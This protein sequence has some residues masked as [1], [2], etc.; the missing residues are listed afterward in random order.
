MFGP[1]VACAAR[2]FHRL[3]YIAVLAAILRDQTNS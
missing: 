1:C 2:I 3:S